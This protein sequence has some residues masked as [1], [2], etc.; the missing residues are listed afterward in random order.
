MTLT[1][2]LTELTMA[3]TANWT[4]I[5]SNDSEAKDLMELLH[6][7]KFS[8]EAAR[9]IVENDYNELEEFALLSDPQVHDLVVNCR[10][11][12]GG[13]D[14][15]IVPTGAE[16][17]L[18]LFAWG[19]MHHARISRT[20]LLDDVTTDWCR[21][22]IYQKNLEDNWKTTVDQLTDSDYPKCDVHNW[23]RTFEGIV[24]L[25]DRVRGRSGRLLS[26]LVR[27]DIVPKDENDDDSS[28][29]ASA[30][31]EVIARA[32]IL[33]LGHDLD[34]PDLELTTNFQFTPEA[35]DDMTQV[36]DILYKIIGSKP[37]WVHAKQTKTTK[38]GRLAFF[39]IKKMVMGEQYISRQVSAL[40]IRINGLTYTGE[41]RQHDMTKYVQQHT[42]CHVN[43]EDLKGEGWPGFDDGSKVRLF[44]AGMKST[45]LDAPKANVICQPD[46][47]QDFNG[48]ARL[49]MDFISATPS[50]QYSAKRGVSEIRGASRNRKVARGRD[51]AKKP[52]S[53]ETLRAMPRIRNK[54]FRNGNPENFVPTTD[55]KSM[56]PPEVDAVWRVREECKAAL[57][58]P[59]GGHTADDKATHALKRSVASLVQELKANKNPPGADP[60]SDDDKDIFPDE[61]MKDNEKHPALGR[62]K[63]GK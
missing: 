28:S 49:F 61:D 18:K 31:K 46:L 1:T 21:G 53:A 35:S 51:K 42:E 48:C 57:K 44:L 45:A 39:L 22:W 9:H 47:M 56:E 12:G 60:D 8:Q 63:R 14:G 55:Y 27:P 58:R 23:P 11:P 7:L 32:P 38:N 54:Y 40:E 50:I 20:I 41:T 26:Y 2:D 33:E 19:A 4:G 37:D 59:A 36:W 24:S 13:T 43:A 62:Q 10:K 16:N 29:Y 30:D 17:Y 6:R 15:M 52:P 5:H 3:R 25:L 34:A